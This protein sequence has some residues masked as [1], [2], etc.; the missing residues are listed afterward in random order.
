MRPT[1]R[2][3]SLTPVG[4]FGFSMPRL[5]SCRS[6]GW[7]SALWS[8]SWQQASRRESRH[9]TDMQGSA[10]IGELSRGLG[11][12]IEGALQ[13]SREPLTFRR[14]DQ[15]AAGFPCEFSADRIL[16]ILNMARD[17]RVRYRQVVSGRSDASHSRKS[18]KSARR[19]QVG[20]GPDHDE[21]LRLTPLSASPLVHGRHQK[22]ALK[23]LVRL[24]HARKAEQGRPHIRGG[25]HCNGRTARPTESPSAQTMPF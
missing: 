19:N 8:S 11:D 1:G 10:S 7:W 5:R 9:A 17:D 21:L 14:Q 24:P 6:G 25:R 20:Q 3:K 16:E 22:A 12:Q 4:L 23:L 2:R 13:L 15:P 18:L